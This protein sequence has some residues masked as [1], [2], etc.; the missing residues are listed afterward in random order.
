[1]SYTIPT[2]E[3]KVETTQRHR[4]AT[5]MALHQRFSAQC[6][7]KDVTLRQLLAKD[8][9]LQSW[10]TPQ[11]DPGEKT[12]WI[13]KQLAANRFIAIMGIIQL[14]KN[15]K[16]S[17]LTI[18]AGESGM[19]T[20]GL[21]ELDEIYSI[22]PILKKLDVDKTIDELFSTFGRLERIRMAAYFSEPYLFK[23]HKVIHITVQSPEGNKTG[24]RLMLQ[25]F[26]IEPAGTSIA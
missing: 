17:E 9:G 4:E 5:I 13:D 26:I 22:L 14:S 7:I 20:L 8:L 21:H 2:W 11:Q 1:M 10:R 24:D 15:P 25:G 3:L 12:V 23:Q 19:L 16:V 18:S 6:D